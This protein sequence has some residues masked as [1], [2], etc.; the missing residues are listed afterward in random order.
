M[1]VTFIMPALYWHYASIYLS[2]S[3]DE[4]TWNERQPKN[5]MNLK[6]RLFLIIDL[7]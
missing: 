3:P 6:T 2:G 1:V 5:G 7:D 4:R